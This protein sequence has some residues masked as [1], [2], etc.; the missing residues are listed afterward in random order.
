MTVVCLHLLSLS[1]H[2][3]SSWRVKRGKEFAPGLTYQPFPDTTANSPPLIVRCIPS[4]LHHCVFQYGFCNPA[5]PLGCFLLRVATCFS[6]ELYDCIAKRTEKSLAGIQKVGQSKGLG[7]ARADRHHME[8]ALPKKTC[9]HK[10]I[11]KDI[12]YVSALLI[13]CLTKWEN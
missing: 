13:K 6:R 4:S 1:T 3:L 5:I 12:T 9:I 8:N 7:L 11:F 2:P 10:R